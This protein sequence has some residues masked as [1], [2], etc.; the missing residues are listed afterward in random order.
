VSDLRR[1]RSIQELAR[2]LR[3]GPVRRSPL[4]P[5]QPHGGRRPFFCVHPVSGSVL[6]YADLAAALGTDRP[7][8]AFEAV[9][10]ADEEPQESIEAMAQRYVREVRR[11]QPDGPYLLGGWS[12]GGLVAHE[13]AR[14]L[15]AQEAHVALV[16]VLDSWANAADAVRSSV[17][18]GVG[19]DGHDGH[20][21][22]RDGLGSDLGLPPEALAWLVEETPPHDA[23]AQLAAVLEQ[24]SQGDLGPHDGPGLQRRLRRVASHVAA[25]R[26]YEPPPSAVRLLVLE[27]EGSR[28]VRQGGL[29]WD[30]LSSDPVRQ[31]VPGDHDTMLRPPHVA[32]V[33]ERLRAAL[34]E[35]DPAG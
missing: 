18:G 9:G 12:M 35:V 27:S 33:A 1:Y 7:F 6:C 5:I 31:V 8:H 17:A 16:A 22:L 29:G 20:V 15:A 26:S 4:V 2:L 19:V 23:E 10:D 3:Q 34:D 13:M 21:A 30:A 11:V 14:Q 24:V 28:R 32:L 25:L